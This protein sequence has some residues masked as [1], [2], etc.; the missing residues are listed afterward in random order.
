MGLYFKRYRIL[1]WSSDIYRLN[2]LK[3]INGY[4]TDYVG[5]GMEDDDLYWRCVRKGYYEQKT[6]QEIKQKMV[7]SLDG[8]STS[9][10]IIHQENLD[11]YL[12][13]VLELILFVNQK[14]QNKTQNI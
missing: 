2:N 8:K 7:L 10:K 12:R 4:N 5:W 11:E 13:I 1:W 3:D 14:Y 9:Y 6:F